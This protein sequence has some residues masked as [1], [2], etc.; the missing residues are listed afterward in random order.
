MTMPWVADN[1]DGTYRNP[2]LHADWSDPDV[3]RVG[4]DFYLVA[5]SFH[6]V[7]GLP[8]LH[9][10]D[11]VNWSIIGHGLP[12]LGPEFDTPQH[13]CG[14]WA[15]AIR[16]H[17]GR[18]WIVYPDPDRGIFVITATDPAGPWS[19]PHLLKGGR[20]LIDPCPLWDD[21]GSAYLVHAWA[22]SRAGFNNKLT[23]HRM[24]PDATVLLDA[25]RH[26][27]D[28]D[29]LP[30]YRT[31]EGPKVYR[32][33]GW[34][35]VFA[36]AGGVPEGWQSAFRSRHVFG[37]Y[38]DR[39]VLA[40]GDTQVNGPHQGAWVTTVDGADWFLHFQDKGAFGRVVHLQPMR[41]VD[42]WPSIGAP[43]G[44][45]VPSFAKPAG[46]GVPTAPAAGDDFAGPDLGAQ[47]SWAG[48]PR[49]GWA[50]FPPG[51]GLR[52][53]CVPGEGDLRQ[54][55][56]V[57]G[58]RL[59]ADRFRATAAL[60]LT[61]TAPGARAGLAIVGR[62]YAWIGIEHT[63]D[64]PVL[65]Q[66]AAAPGE[67]ERD[68]AP[69]AA[70][71]GSPVAVGVEVAPDARCQFLAGDRPIGPPFVATAGQWVGAT[72][73][74]FATGEDGAAEFAALGVTAC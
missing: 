27:V 47:W 58:Q 13:G 21:D 2:V 37:P 48:N 5:S 73:G 44:Q 54:L 28:G 3:I 35:W 68:A 63:R 26:I 65:V 56:N 17:D 71:G 16:H 43:P 39:I 61:G 70:L 10:R 25:G 59:P 40:Q 36:P 32:R 57:L 67:P 1:G 18:F 23:C 19:R 60:R 72:L 9:S 51:G 6:R 24:S 30:G 50:S 62:G 49:D 11:L 55:P 52:L 7:P 34:Y 31:L 33:D 74:L 38:E 12:S 20:G 69:P 66:R 4:E 45:P 29:A 22:K 42:G 46:A 64:G 14:V 8:I 53:A 41:W 15:P